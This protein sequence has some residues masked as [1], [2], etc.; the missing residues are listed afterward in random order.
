MHVALWMILEFVED[1]DGRHF[2][3]IFP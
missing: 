2:Q 3:F 1:R